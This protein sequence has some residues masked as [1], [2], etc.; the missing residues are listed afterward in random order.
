MDPGSGVNDITQFAGTS[1]AVL[2][3]QNGYTAGTLENFS[4]DN[5]GVITG[6]FTNGVNVALL[7][8]SRW[9]TS[10]TRPVCSASATTC[11]S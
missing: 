10:T 6:A 3:D 4:I 8:R 2:Q 5:N 1:T 9:P 11:T 7:R